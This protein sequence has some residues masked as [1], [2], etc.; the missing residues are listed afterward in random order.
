MPSV[1]SRHL[2]TVAAIATLAFA[3]GCSDRAPVTEPAAAG[4]A[5]RL[6]GV[7]IPRPNPSAYVEI[8]AGVDFT[9]ARRN[10]GTVICWGALIDAGSHPTAVRMPNA[11]LDTLRALSIS[12]GGA[13][14]CAV[15]TASDGICWGNGY[16][17]QLGNNVAYGDMQPALV[18]GGHKFFA[19]GGGTAVTCGVATHGAF[20]W[21]RHPDWNNPIS[22]DINAPVQISSF[23]GYRTVTVGTEHACSLGAGSGGQEVDCWGIDSSGQQAID[24]AMFQPFVPFTIRSLFSTPVRRVSANDSTTCA[25]LTSGVVQCA[26][27]N[28]RGQL[29]NGTTG[30][31]SFQPQMVSGGHVFH[32]VSVGTGH[33][34]AIDD[35]NRAFCWGK[36]DWG[37]LGD[38]TL[39]QA[40]VPVAVSGGLTFTAIAAGYNHTCAIGTDNGLY[41]WGANY[42]GQAGQGTMNNIA[43]VNPGRVHDP[44]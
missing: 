38:G 18:F 34:C 22:N 39:N 25:E 8:S 2:S 33:V 10:S 29:G 7:P 11:T 27:Q 30:G 31:S 17:G 26:G 28:G 15:N 19:I 5:S 6:I 9:C 36:N 4:S 24:P 43:W 1:V 21:G 40:N 44:R 12:A 13:H 23:N 42:Y 3:L 32:G 16:A 20:C 14:M 41:C 35:Q 37:Q